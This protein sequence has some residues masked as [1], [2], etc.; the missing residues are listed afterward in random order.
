MRE[1]DLESAQVVAKVYVLY[2]TGSELANEFDVR[3]NVNDL[4]SSSNINKD[5]EKLV[6]VNRK[7]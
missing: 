2:V 7:L 3:E 6:S 1:S 4:C 5:R